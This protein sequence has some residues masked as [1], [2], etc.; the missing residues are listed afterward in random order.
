MLKMPDKVKMEPI[1]PGYMFA[2]T[3]SPNHRFTPSPNPPTMYTPMG[4]NLSPFSATPTR[5]DFQF[6]PQIF[7]STSGPTLSSTSPMRYDHQPSTLNPQLMNP[8]PF[9]LSTNLPPLSSLKPLQAYQTSPNPEPPT[10]INEPEPRSNSTSISMIL[11]DMDSQ[12]IVMNF[13]SSDL[14]EMSKL[15]GAPNA[16]RNQALDYDVEENM[17]DSLTR[18]KLNDLN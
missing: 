10:T 14:T 18:C 6:I 4:P 16:D 2:N 9:N 13:N 11:R 1:S 12:Q 7:P 3:P 15:L 8:D 17:S 5:N